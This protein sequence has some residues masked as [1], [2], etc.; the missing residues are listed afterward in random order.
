MNVRI[1]ATSLHSN[2]CRVA[3][4]LDF[5]MSCEIT[6]SLHYWIVTLLCDFC[7]TLIHHVYS[8]PQVKPLQEQSKRSISAAEIDRL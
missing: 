1:E 5:W 2:T 8:Q 6:Q 7:A 4:E 3:Q